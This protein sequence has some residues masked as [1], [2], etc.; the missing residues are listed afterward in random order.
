MYC[1]ENEEER[2]SSCPIEIWT[3]NIYI[4]GYM[5]N[6]RLANCR[7]NAFGNPRRLPCTR[8]YGAFPE[9]RMRRR[10][11]TT[12]GGTYAHPLGW[13]ACSYICARILHH[14]TSS[15]VESYGGRELQS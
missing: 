9:S 4:V 15:D 11:L 6:D 7:V 1:N 13:R 2:Q 10:P 5:K 12:V 8:E 3:V 14:A